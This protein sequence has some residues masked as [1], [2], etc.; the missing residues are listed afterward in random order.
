LLGR[1]ETPGREMALPCRM[2]AFACLFLSHP[3]K[4]RITVLPRARSGEVGTASAK[5]IMRHNENESGID[6]SEMIPL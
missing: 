2:P 6:H 5:K 3:I 1:K 4:Q